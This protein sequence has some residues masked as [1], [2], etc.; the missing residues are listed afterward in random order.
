MLQQCQ[1][2]NFWQNYFNN[3]KTLLD[4]EKYLED[5]N[6]NKDILKNLLRWKKTMIFGEEVQRISSHFS[7]DMT[8]NAGVRCTNYNESDLLILFFQ[9]FW[10]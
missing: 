5:W 4:N 1:I 9:R 10:I 2:Q 7:V 6:F 8:K 3:L